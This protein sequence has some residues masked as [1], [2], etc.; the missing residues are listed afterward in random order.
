MKMHMR[1]YEK[2]PDI[3]AVVHARSTYGTIFAIAGIPL[4]APIMSEA[5]VSLGCVPVAEYGTPSTAEI[6]DSIEKYLPYY[7]AIL[8]EHHGALTWSNTLEAAYMKMESLEFYAELIYR[9][10]LLGVAREFDLEDIQKLYEVR[11]NMN[12]S[13]KHPATATAEE[14]A[15]AKKMGMQGYQYD[16][17]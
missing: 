8:L 7:D 9:T 4:D 6:P 3:C 16:F 2:R 17:L 15:E 14:V 5:V 11:R 10:K 13:G 12:M 1:V